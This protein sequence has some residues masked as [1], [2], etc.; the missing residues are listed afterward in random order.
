MATLS[1]SILRINESSSYY[2]LL[3][4]RMNIVKG[5]ARGGWSKGHIPCTIKPQ[6]M[7]KFKT[8]KAALEFWSKYNNVDQEL[9]FYKVVELTVDY[10]LN[11]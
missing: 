6:N 1:N 5:I 11:L 2:V 8:E 3:V 7:M 9:G 10:N 4:K